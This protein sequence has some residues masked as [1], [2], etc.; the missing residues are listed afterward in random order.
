MRNLLTNKSGHYTGIAIGISAQLKCLFEGLFEKDTQIVVS[1]RS[2]QEVEWQHKGMLDA[3]HVIV[4]SLLTRQ[5]IVAS[6]HK[7][8]VIRRVVS[9]EIEVLSQ[10]K[11][12]KAIESLML[13]FCSSEFLFFGEL[14]SM[15]KGFLG[16]IL[17][18]EVAEKES[19]GIAVH[20]HNFLNDWISMWKLCITQNCLLNFSTCLQR[21]CPSSKRHYSCQC[22]VSHRW[23]V[24]ILSLV[25]SLESLCGRFQRKIASCIILKWIICNPLIIL[26]SN[27]IN[28]KNIFWICC[29]VLI[30]F[31]QCPK[32]LNSHFRR[33]TQLSWPYWWLSAAT[34]F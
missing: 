6:F 9:L 29:S 30:W 14:Q 34:K 3:S 27:Q 33:V 10:V 22:R 11:Q 25:F 28:V 24:H 8:N 2:Q 16:T 20:K 4:R 26:Q 7:S 19:N 18:V 23:L 1:D 15:T 32:Q 31:N 12:I 21:G 13:G 5:T 17:I